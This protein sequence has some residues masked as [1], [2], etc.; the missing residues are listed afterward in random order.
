MGEREPLTFEDREIISRELSQPRSAPLIGLLPGRHHSVISREIERNG[1]G[2]V[3]RA[4]E[5]QRRCNEV[6]LRPRR[7][8]LE[9]FP[10]L[11]DSAECFG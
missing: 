10:R 5:A 6:R 2:R 7:R 1:S 3:Y 8:K 11:H 9:A 4:V